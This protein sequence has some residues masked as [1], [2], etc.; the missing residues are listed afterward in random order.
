MAGYLRLA[1]GFGVGAAI[2]GVVASFELDLPMGAAIAASAA[3]LH[4]P[5]FALRRLAA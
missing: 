2:V 1:V 3:L 4:L 5:G